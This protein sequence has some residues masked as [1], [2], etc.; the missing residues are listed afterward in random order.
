MKILVC[1]DSH[2]DVQALLQAVAWSEPDMML[3]LGDGEKDCA[4]VAANYPAL[5]IRK[6]YGNC[7]FGSQ[8]PAT[9]EFTEDGK[10][11]FMT[12]GHKFSVKSGLGSLVREACARCADVVLFGHTH[13]PF[14]MN[15][16]ELCIINPGSIGADTHDFGVMTTGRKMRYD[17]C[18]IGSGD[19][20]PH[21]AES[22]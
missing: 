11:F 2:G 4:S 14:Y 19:I 1:S 18:S 22:Y 12:H 16:D 21:I 6:V 9:D 5:L 8:E 10:R 20:L 15:T 17:A 7:D 3:F 13:R